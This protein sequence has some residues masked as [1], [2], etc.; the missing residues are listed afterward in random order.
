MKSK[1][2]S[3]MKTSE[4]PNQSIGRSV[5]RNM[6]VMF[7][8]QAVNWVSSFL[9]LYFLPRLLGS[10]D[11]GRLYL[12]L[13]IKMM[14]GLLIDFGGNYLIPKEVAR[15]EKTG[16]FILSSYIILRV[17]LW[18]LSIGAIILFS[19]LLGYSQHVHF[20]ILILAVGKLWEGA[21]S[22]IGAYFQGIEQMEYPS[23]GNIIE[24]LTVAVFSIAALLM[25]ADSIVIAIIM[26]SAALLNLLVLMYFSRNVL[27]ISYGFSFKVFGLLKTGMPYFLFSLFSVI[28]Y[29]IDAV[30]IAAFTNESVT[31][32][33]GGAFRFFDIVMIFPLIYK[34]AIFPVFS[35]LWDDTKGKLEETISESLRLMII[36]G[37]PVA[38]VVF[39]YAE[40]II[41]F[42]M[43]L[44][45]YGPS[46]LILQIFSAS[47]PII[48]LD[49][50][51][52][53]ALLSAANKQN[54]WAMVGFA[55]IFV[56][57]VLNYFLIPYSQE[58]FMNGGT[59]AALSTL[60]T[61][62]FMMSAAFVLLP[63]GYLKGFKASY[64]SKPAFS[65][66]VMG[67][68]V[69]GF[70]MI[71]LYWML[72]MVSGLIVYICSLLLIK[73]FA[74]QELKLLKEFISVEHLKGF[75]KT[76]EASE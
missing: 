49:I 25:G 28:Y 63:K 55:A 4:A 50:I 45:E 32:W 27:K 42:F 41:H 21:Y 11:Y 16:S 47:I 23:L 46:V 71:G 31:G 65:T 73:T 70:N 53:S 61:E 38:L 30:M 54:E 48:Y 29:R 59:G 24:R 18:V 57:I 8:A 60:F 43:G 67:A 58:Y 26:A 9:L 36:L 76:S 64:V 66:V 44:D 72:S 19:H 35:R 1:K 62:L 6:S 74:P 68:I 75:L 2:R 69:W 15:S 5:A 39:V 14:L 40:S 37:L 3:N 17:L 7:S 56:N 12:A 51:L 22:A 52:G 20:L 13:S 34:T 33:Y 10:E